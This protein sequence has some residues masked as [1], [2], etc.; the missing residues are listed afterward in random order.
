[1]QLLAIVCFSGSN[2]IYPNGGEYSYNC[3][4][5]S[6]SIHQTE[7]FVQFYNNTFVNGAVSIGQEANEPYI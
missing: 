4:D 6:F 7:N 1:M 2:K 5:D 3:F